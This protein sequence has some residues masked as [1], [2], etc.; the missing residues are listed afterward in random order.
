MAGWV[1]ERVKHFHYD[2]VLLNF[3]G[4]VAQCVTASNLEPRGF[5]LK[6]RCTLGWVLARNLTTALRVT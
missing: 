5:G 4:R 2:E 6:H 1:G 3:S